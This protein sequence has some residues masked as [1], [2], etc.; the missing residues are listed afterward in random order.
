[1]SGWAR[2]PFFSP[3]LFRRCRRPSRR[4]LTA[5]PSYVS[6]PPSSFSHAVLVLPRRHRAPPSPAADPAWRSPPRSSALS[7]YGFGVEVTAAELCPP[8]RIVPLPSGRAPS[9]AP[10]AGEPRGSVAP[11]SIWPQASL[12]AMTAELPSAKWRQRSMG[13]VSLS[14]PP[15]SSLPR[16]P[17]LPHHRRSLATRRR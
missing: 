9:P 3:T 1:M 5:P 15:R 17:R 7:C 4:S 11:S 16:H 6:A 8:Y 13:G 12:C 10:L 2:L 14:S